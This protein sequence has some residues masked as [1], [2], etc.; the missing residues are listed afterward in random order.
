MQVTGNKSFRCIEN[1][2]AGSDPVPSAMYHISILLRPDGFSFCVYRP[3]DR[4]MQMYRNYEIVSAALPAVT[5]AAAWEA[6]GKAYAGV[7]LEDEWLQQTYAACDVYSDFPLSTLVPSAFADPDLA[8]LYFQ[9]CADGLAS[10]M[11]FHSEPLASGDASVFFGVPT[12]WETLWQ[13]LSTA[14]RWHHLTTGLVEHLQ[15]QADGCR[16]H[17]AL[18][19]GHVAVLLHDSVRG[20]LHHQTYEACTAADVLYYALGVLQLHGVAP[21]ACAVTCQSTTT[22]LAA[23]EVCGMLRP[24]FGD[25]SSLTDAGTWQGPPFDSLN[26]PQ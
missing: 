7:F 10:Q 14:V 2:S 23:D 13:P 11:A 8:D 22:R 26:T 25:V 9:P 3:S 17:L 18:T 15:R 16:L 19:A 24:W 20:M 21:S 4:Q 1:L 6:A 5:D 12:A